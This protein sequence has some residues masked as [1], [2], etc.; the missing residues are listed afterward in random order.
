MLKKTTPWLEGSF[1]WRTPVWW[2]APLLLT[3]I[4]CSLQSHFTH[5]YSE[6]QS[7]P[8]TAWS[9]PY[10]QDLFLRSPPAETA[11]LVYSAPSKHQFLEGITHWFLNSE[12]KYHAWHEGGFIKHEGSFHQNGILIQTGLREILEGN[13]YRDVEPFLTVRLRICRQ[14]DRVL[15]RRTFDEDSRPVHWYQ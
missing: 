2:N 5:S 1:S 3:S 13:E 15:V 4:H 6:F 10:R 8:N 12:I 11:S 9:S 7:W 14:M